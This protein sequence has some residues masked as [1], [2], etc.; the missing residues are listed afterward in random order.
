MRVRTR[1]TVL[2]VAGGILLGSVLTF[3]V[4]ADLGRRTREQRGYTPIPVP[5]GTPQ[6]TPSTTPTPAPIP[7]SPEATA[8]SLGSERDLDALGVVADLPAGYRFAT[9]L[10]A[11][12]ASRPGTAPRV[13]LTKATEAQEQAYLT[14]LRTLSQAQAGT[15]VPEFVPGHA[16]VLSLVTDPSEQAFSAQLAKAKTPLTTTQGLSGTRYA[17]VEGLSTYD[18][19][20]L[21]VGEGKTLALT[22]AYAVDEPRFDEAAYRGVVNSVRPR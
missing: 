12:A 6:P 7:P 2:S 19:T 14:L 4:L 20:Y 18:V 21:V 17:R 10:N 5:V 1:R 16:I 13:T 3:L 11:F 9:A 15:E 8:E 22:M